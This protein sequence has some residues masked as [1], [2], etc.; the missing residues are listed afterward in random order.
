MDSCFALPPVDQTRQYLD[1]RFFAVF[2]RRFE[3]S[4]LAEFIY[5]ISHFVQ[6]IKR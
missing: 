2:V 5:M 3:L 1:V 6:R 4:A